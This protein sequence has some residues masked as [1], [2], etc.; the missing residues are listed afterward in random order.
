MKKL[1]SIISLV[2][3][4]QTRYL[5]KT[6]EF[7]IDMPKTVKEAAELDAKAMSLEDPMQILSLTHENMK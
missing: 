5:K 3:K 6:H 7:G 2:K 4:Q 1:D